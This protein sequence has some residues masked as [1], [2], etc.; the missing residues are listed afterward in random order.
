[1]AEPINEFKDEFADTFVSSNI[2]PTLDVT[3]HNKDVFGENLSMPA[4]MTRFINAQAQSQTEI[5]NILSPLLYP[6]SFYGLVLIQ[7]ACLISSPLNQ[8]SAQ[9]SNT[10]QWHSPILVQNS[11][12]IFFFFFSSFFRGSSSQYKKPHK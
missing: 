7:L 3:D 1:M 4:L 11:C 2:I 12:L 8:L 10:A 9:S 5:F 6:E